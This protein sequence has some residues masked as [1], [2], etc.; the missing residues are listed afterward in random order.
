MALDDFR[1]IEINID[2]ANDYIAPIMLSS[3]DAN[4]RTL[5]VKLTDNG[6]TISSTDGIVAKL[7]YDDKRGN[8]GFKTMSAVDGLETAAWEC[9]APG[10]ILNG[11]YALLCI[12][13]WQ[14][15]DVV[16]SRVFRANVDRSLICL[17]PGTESGDAVKELYDAIAKLN[18]TIEDAGDTL[19]STVSAA[20]AAVDTAVGRAD[21]S[22]TRAD[23]S[24]SAADVSTAAASIAAD[25]A[26]KAAAQ[27]NAAASATKPYYMQAAEPTRDKRVDGMLWMQTNESTMKLAAFKRWDANL[28]GKAVFPGASTMPGA[29]TIIDEI[30]AWTTFAL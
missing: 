2:T 29:S 27:A 1:R 22:A 20:N 19:N 3:G 30:G 26:T 21:A 8:S 10:S 24:A 4:G 12:Q 28:P 15:A 14:G 5:L 7:A 11:D 23:S 25:A 6:K 18:K 16:C 13:F 17:D 9:S